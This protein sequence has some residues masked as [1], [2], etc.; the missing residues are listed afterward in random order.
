MRRDE[1]D[2][3]YKV[4]SLKKN[5]HIPV[6]N[7]LDSSFEKLTNYLQVLEYILVNLMNEKLYFKLRLKKNK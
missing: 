3:L 1:S 2:M 4:L 6:P 7:Q 5:I